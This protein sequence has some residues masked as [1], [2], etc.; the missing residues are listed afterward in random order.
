M[1]CPASVNCAKRYAADSLGNGKV[2]K[3]KMAYREQFGRGR[4]WDPVEKCGNPCSSRGVD[5]YLS[6]ESIQQKRVSAPVNQAR[7][8]LAH[9]L[10]GL[11]ESMRSRVQLELS[12][13]QRTTII[14]DMALFSLVFA[15]MRRG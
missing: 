7:P 13:A 10:T 2:S 11:S 6:Y 1:N 14:R 9:V 4:E 5:S 3:L 15:T 12:L 8:M